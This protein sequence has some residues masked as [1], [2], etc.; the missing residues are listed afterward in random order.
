MSHT[1]NSKPHKAAVVAKASPA[2]ALE[3][4]LD[5]Y[6]QQEEAKGAF[7]HYAR[8]ADFLDELEARRKQPRHALRTAAA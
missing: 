3:A 4:K 6:I 1:N 2:A 5:R 8:A 7:K